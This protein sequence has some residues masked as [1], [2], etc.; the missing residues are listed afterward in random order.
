MKKDGHLSDSHLFTNEEKERR[1]KLQNLKNWLLK[2]SL[3]QKTNELN[4]LQ[5]CSL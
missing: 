2:K 3:N 1:L 4:N 5:A